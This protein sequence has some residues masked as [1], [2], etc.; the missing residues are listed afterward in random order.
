MQIRNRA[1]A[2]RRFVARS[3]AAPL[4][5]SAPG[6]LIYTLCDLYIYIYR[7]LQ[8]AAVPAAEVQVNRKFTSD[9]TRD[10]HP[11]IRAVPAGSYKRLLLLLILPLSPFDPPKGPLTRYLCIGTRIPLVFHRDTQRG[12]KPPQATKISQPW[13]EI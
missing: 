6:C 11:K 13:S 5:S 12:Y 3:T 7:H 9:S 1:W 10:N 4:S 8:S 2:S